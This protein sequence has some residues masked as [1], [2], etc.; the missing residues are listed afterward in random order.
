MEIQQYQRIIIAI[1]VHKHSNPVNYRNVSQKKYQSGCVVQAP[2]LCKCISVITAY[3]FQERSHVQL[4]VFWE[5]SCYIFKD[6]IAY[7]ERNEFFA[8]VCTACVQVNLRAS[9]RFSWRA[10]LGMD[11]TVLSSFYRHVCQCCI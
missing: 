4:I 2:H 11:E 10:C 6:A 1:T 8:M 5:L 3:I 9:V 7:V